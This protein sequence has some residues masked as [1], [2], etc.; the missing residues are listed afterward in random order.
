MNQRLR[1]LVQDRDQGCC[2]RCGHYC[3]NEPHSVHHRQPKG[4]GGRKGADTPSNLIL[5]CGSGSTGCH[6]YVHSRADRS[7]DLG[8]LVR[9][10]HDPATSPLW[11][12]PDEWV[13]LTVDGAVVPVTAIP[14]EESA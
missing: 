4:M 2:V 8:Y 13:L 3:L 7:R 10:R 12:P 9:S 11:R 14:D 5:L 6:G 1:R